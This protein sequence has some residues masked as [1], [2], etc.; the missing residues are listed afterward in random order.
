[1]PRN[2]QQKSSA[3]F[4][5]AGNAGDG[6]H[7]HSRRDEHRVHTTL[8]EWLA[9][10]GAPWRPF[11]DKGELVAARPNTAPDQRPSRADLFDRTCEEQL[12]KHLKAVCLWPARDRDKT[13][14]LGDFSSYALEFN[15]PGR[16]AVSVQFWSEPDERTNG[17]AVTFEVASDAWGGSG[18]RVLDA[19]RQ[20]MLRDHGFERASRRNGT[21]ANGH[22]RKEVLLASGRSIRA[23]MRETI[24]ILCKVLDYDGSTPLE[25]RLH[26]GTRLN[27]GYTFDGICAQDLLK[28]M[29]RWG[30]PA[31]LEEHTGQAPLIK[32]IV[33]E[34]PF[35][36]AFVGE[37]QGVAG[38]YG[39]IGLRT[40]MRFE[41]GVPDGL[42]N[43][44]NT[45]FAT[46]KASIDEDGDLVVQTPIIL[47][48]GVASANLE[49]CFNVW[50]ETLEEILQGLE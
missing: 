8:T 41:G 15:P 11:V 3:P 47:H 1:M 24:A 44:I 37:R 17:G 26:L 40:F 7:S 16:A 29:H 35:L 20:D 21:T 38:E 25:F 34:Q 39:M 43:A 46:V 9:T 36:V 14:R 19:A 32:S 28:L 12:L 48:G 33:Q 13:W 10:D 30:L 31:E 5:A 49:M 27:A 6:A 23:L 42:P 2:R 18:R 22:F 50:R 4:G 45:S